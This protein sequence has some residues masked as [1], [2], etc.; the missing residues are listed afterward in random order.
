[1][2]VFIAS[3]HGG[4]N[5]KAQ[6][7][8]TDLDLQNSNQYKFVDLGPFELNEDDDYPHFAEKLV[9][10]MQKEPESLGILICRS[11]IG[12]SIAANKFK[13]IYAA[14]AI[15]EEH[16][17][18]AREHNNANILCLDSDYEDTQTHI[19]IVKAFLSSEFEGWE[20]R[21]GRRIRQIQSF[22]DKNFK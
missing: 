9:M 1:M 20:T 7:L 10:E 8:N 22:E 17:K 21:H 16:A 4:F 19:N 13:G 5:L 6:M 11:G 2:K 15:R 14:L 12:M 18:K 3:D